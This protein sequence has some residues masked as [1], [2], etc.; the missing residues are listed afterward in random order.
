MTASN[1]GAISQVSEA[2]RGIYCAI[3]ICEAL[4]IV[5]V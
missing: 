3:T 4:L 5:I 1:A 2:A